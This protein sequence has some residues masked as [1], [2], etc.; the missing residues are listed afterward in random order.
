MD[1]QVDPHPADILVYHSVYRAFH[2][3]TRFN[4]AGV[5]NTCDGQFHVASVGGKNHLGRV[6]LARKLTDTE[7]NVADVSIFLRRLILFL[8]FRRTS[9]PKFIS[10]C[11]QS[12]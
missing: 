3:K 12:T 8:K 6:Y 9:G 2:P 10:K 1:P 11:F 5:D 7:R 4:A